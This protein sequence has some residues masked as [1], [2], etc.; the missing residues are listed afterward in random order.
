MGV[1]TKAGGYVVGIDGGGTKTLGVL[2]DLDGRIVRSYAGGTSNVQLL[3]YEGAARE[4]LKVIRNCCCRAGVTIRDVNS[5]VVGLAGAGREADRKHTERAM[6]GL[7]RRQRIPLGDF[8][9]ESDARVA[10]EGALDGTPGV[11]IISGT[12]SIGL[13]KNARGRVFRVGG[14]GRVIGDEA[15]GYA[16]GRRALSAIAKSI[17]GRGEPTLLKT[18][19]SRTFGLSSPERIVRKVYQRNLDIANLAPLVLRAADKGD[20]VSRK[21]LDEATHDLLDH[22]RVLVKKIKPSGE[23]RRGGKIRVVLLGGLLQNANYLSKKL[24][25]KIQSEFPAI[26]IEGAIKS[27]AGGAILLALNQWKQRSRT[28][29]R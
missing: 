16:I 21:I 26:R 22:L 25:K 5:V 2:A 9:V 11:V 18:M 13:A 10:L 15:S 28:F 4:V 3:G 19:A 27:P 7:A 29:R 8:R 17:D 1:G 6:R 14:W 20:R 12:G 23:P 24:K